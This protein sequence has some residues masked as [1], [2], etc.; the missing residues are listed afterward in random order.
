M[1]RSHK[2]ELQGKTYQRPDGAEPVPENP[3]EGLPARPPRPPIK[4]TAPSET[5]GETPRTR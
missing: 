3:K 5:R 4:P 1:A 2:Q